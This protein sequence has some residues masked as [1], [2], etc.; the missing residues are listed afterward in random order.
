MS[1]R[2]ARSKTT[3]CIFKGILIISA[4]LRSGYR[5]WFMISLLIAQFRQPVVVN[6]KEMG[7]LV[8]N[9]D[10]DFL[11]KFFEGVAHLL[12]GFLKDKNGVRIDW[13]RKY[14]VLHKR[15][16]LVK[17][18][19][20]IVRGHPQIVQ[21]FSRGAFPNRNDYVFQMFPDSFRNTVKGPS[22]S[23]I[24]FLLAEFHFSRQMVIRHEPI[25]CTRS[26]AC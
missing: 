19:R 20:W 23:L 12:Q 13:R 18:Q 8:H 14:G 15:D 25:S 24:K 17:A 7:N 2:V 3:A 9:G 22:D 1:G 6:A 26:V 5:E 16:A 10:L 4:Y 21:H 11:L